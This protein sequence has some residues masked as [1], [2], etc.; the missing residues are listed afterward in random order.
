VSATMTLRTISAQWANSSLQLVS[1]RTRHVCSPAIGGHGQASKKY[2]VTIGHAR[3][4]VLTHDHAGRRGCTLCGQCLWG[5]DLDSIYSARYDLEALQRFSTFEYRAGVFVSRLERQATPRLICRVQGRHDLEVIDARRVILACGTLGST[6]LVLRALA[7][8]DLELQLLS[9][10]AAAFAVLLPE[11]LGRTVDPLI[12]GL[13]QLTL[14]HRDETNGDV[15]YGN[16]FEAGPVP[17]IDVARHINVLRPT[18]R[19][20][21]GVMGP[22]CW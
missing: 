14:L 7:I 2:G 18:A 6:A 12:F 8:R 22:A 17:L 21:L 13:S 1:G 19:R 9:T 4:A 3:N 16:L 5:C 15:A 10:P 20:M 11:R